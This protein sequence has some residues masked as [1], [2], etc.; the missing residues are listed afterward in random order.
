MKLLGGFTG[1]MDVNL[2]KLWEMVKDREAWP[3]AVHGVA[4]SDTTE[5]LNKGRVPRY[6]KQL[7]VV[8]VKCEFLFAH[9]GSATWGRCR[10]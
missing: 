3:A 9:F 1:S 10:S 2:S 4:E 8:Y 5:R 7:F 6:A